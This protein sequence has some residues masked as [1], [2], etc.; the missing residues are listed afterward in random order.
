MK[1][2]LS[3]LA[4]SG[5]YSATTF[6]LAGKGALQLPSREDGV[7]ARHFDVEMVLKHQRDGVLR[8]QIE[9]AGTN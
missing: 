7:I 5:K 3:A 2:A 4:H 9:V 1:Q 8:G 6:N